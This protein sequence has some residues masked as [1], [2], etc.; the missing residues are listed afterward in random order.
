MV[1]SRRAGSVEGTSHYLGWRSSSDSAPEAPAVGSVW[2]LAGFLH[3]RLS[4]A[5]RPRSA[6]W[7]DPPVAPSATALM[8]SPDVMRSFCVVSR[9]YPFSRTRS[10]DLVFFAFG[11]L[12]SKVFFCTQ[13][14]HCA[15]AEVWMRK[16]PL[17]TC[18]VSP[19]QFRVQPSLLSLTNP[20]HTQHKCSLWL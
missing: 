5:S 13:E 1:F 9:M 8:V 14:L 3:C 12:K 16:S 20:F 19:V 15:C 18:P 2:I 4:S 6:S 11:S 7:S 10:E 17:Q